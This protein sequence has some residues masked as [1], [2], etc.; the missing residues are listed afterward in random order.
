[1]LV[2]AAIAEAVTGLALLV[3]PSL[4]GQLL[5]GQQLAGVAIPVT[6]VTGIALIAMGISRWPAT[7]LIGMFAYSSVAT[8]Y[9]AYV[10][11]VGEFSGVLLCPRFTPERDVHLGRRRAHIPV[12][13]RTEYASLLILPDH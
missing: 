11:F 10:G 5:F 2:F 9:F 12:V 6:R 7:P 4:V 3:I 13:P 1:V 8:P